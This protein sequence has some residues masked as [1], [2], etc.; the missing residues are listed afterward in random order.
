LHAA[1]FG[2]H[3][4]IVALLLARGANVEVKNDLGLVPKQEAFDKETRKVCA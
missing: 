3:A 4:D 1:G 2:K